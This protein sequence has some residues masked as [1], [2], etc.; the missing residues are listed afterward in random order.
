MPNLKALLRA[1]LLFLLAPTLLAPACTRAVYLGDNGD[2]ITAR[3]M[4][5]KMD[6]L[7]NL[8]I[9]PRGMQ[10]S[11]EAGPN[12][13][14]WTSKYGSVIASGYDISITDG[15]NEAGLNVNLLWLVESQY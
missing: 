5:W 8:L 11:G 3:S 7:T 1:A 10:R 6:V 12:S 4:D 14:H 13:V 9:F 15:L 2:V